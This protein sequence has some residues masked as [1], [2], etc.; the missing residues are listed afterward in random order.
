MFVIPTAIANT[1]I[2][3]YAFIDATKIVTTNQITIAITW[4]ALPELCGNVGSRW[5]PLHGRSYIKDNYLECAAYVR[6]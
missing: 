5:F 3:V 4:Y 1:C 6:L 2:R